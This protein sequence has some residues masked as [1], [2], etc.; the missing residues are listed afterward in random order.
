MSLEKTSPLM[1]SLAEEISCARTFPL[2][3]G[4]PG[5]KSLPL[6]ILAAGSVNED[7]L[8]EYKEEVILSETGW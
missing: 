5:Q 2:G 8:L 3:N 4:L 7:K 6:G 1:V